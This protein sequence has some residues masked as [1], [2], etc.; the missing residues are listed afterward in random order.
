MR[1][2]VLNWKDPWHPMAGGAERYTLEV[3]RRLE[4]R[5]HALTWFSPMYPGASPESEVE[6]IRFVRAGGR[7]SVYGAA[8]RFV[9]SLSGPRQPDVVLDEV[10]TVPFFA[11]ECAR[12][13]TKVVNLVHAIARDVWNYETPFPVSV[14]GRYWLEDRWLRRISRC[15]TITVSESSRRDL[16]SLGFRDL[17]VAHNGPPEP[18]PEANG[19]VETARSGILYIG[20]LS[21]Y[22]CPE[23]AIRAVLHGPKQPAPR[24]TVIGDGPLLSR[25]VR[26][27]PGVDFRGKLGDAE[28][29][30]YL[31]RAAILLVPGVREGWGRVVLEAQSVGTVPIVYDVPGLRD[32]VDFGAAGALVSPPNWHEMAEVL[33]GLLGNPAEL[34]RLA[35]AGKAWGRRFDWDTTTDIVESVLRRA[36]DPSEK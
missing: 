30:Q 33:D 4:R 31:R 29:W 18:A 16:E 7:Y 11:C 21:P 26:R 34:S 32:A 1:I 5:G 14:L 15:P 8:R 24:L 20:R 23:D 13:P 35:V 10:N 2:V 17:T 28:K 19:P 3:A 9:R 27:Y 12:A 25:L 6:G 22:K 36:V